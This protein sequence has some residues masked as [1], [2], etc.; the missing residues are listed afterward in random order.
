MTMTTGTSVSESDLTFGADQ[1]FG[2]M[3]GSIH[4]H[5]VCL[6]RALYPAALLDA[7]AEAA[8]A[9]YAHRDGLV[10]RNELPPEM[11]VLHGVD[12]SIIVSD[13]VIQGIPAAHLL[14]FDLLRSIAGVCLR[15]PQPAV[16]HDSY[17]RCVRPITGEGELPYHQDSRV[18]KC[19]LINVWLP[20]VDCGRDRPA[21]EVIPQRLYDLT[22]TTQGDHSRL[23]EIG[24]EID[25]ATVRDTFGPDNAWH[26]EMAKGD[27]LVFYCTT[28]HRSY[29][30]PAM[31]IERTSIDLRLY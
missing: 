16:H 17:V 20:F 31:R 10:A 14:A 9:V 21:L 6:I 12:R 15:K 5:G 13:I 25:A 26:P 18:L 28:I 11:T 2:E 29:V 1:H 23:A 24:V 4:R 7:I 22:P 30:T 8:A 19:P 27:A 3:A